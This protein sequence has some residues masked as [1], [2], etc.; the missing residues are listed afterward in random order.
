MTAAWTIIMEAAMTQ[1]GKVKKE[2]KEF[3]DSLG[4][5]CWYFSPQM[6]G[7]GRAGIPDII[8]CLRGMFFAIEVKAPGKKTNVTPWQVKEILAVRNAIGL[9]CIA[10][11]VDDVKRMLL[12]AL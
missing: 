11:C 7:Y 10:D 6:T 12:N 5:Y 8:G 3:L 9:V 1:E 4:Q 2:I